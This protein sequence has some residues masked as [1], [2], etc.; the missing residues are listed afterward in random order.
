MRAEPGRMNLKKCFTATYFGDCD[1]AVLST[2]VWVPTAL[3]SLICQYSHP[4]SWPAVRAW[5]SFIAMEKA[6][7]DGKPVDGDSHT[8][9]S[10]EVSVIHDFLW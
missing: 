5:C 10:P 3:P 1:K 9:S 6:P 8:V 2:R 4:D 7:L